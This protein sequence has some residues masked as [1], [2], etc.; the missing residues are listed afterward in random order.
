MSDVPATSSGAR[1][2]AARKRRDLLGDRV[3][4]FDQE[5]SRVDRVR[6]RTV[7]TP[8]ATHPRF[9]VDGSGRGR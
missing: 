2:V 6:T 3:R 4:F 7:E 5:A 8:T 1:T 9:D